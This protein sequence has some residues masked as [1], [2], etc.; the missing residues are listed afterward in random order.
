MDGE[1]S[2]GASEVTSKGYEGLFCDFPEFSS[3]Q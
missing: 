1:S 3:I 2:P